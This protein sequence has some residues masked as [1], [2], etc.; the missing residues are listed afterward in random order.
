M[1]KKSTPT[2]F[3]NRQPNID[4]IKSEQYTKDNTPPVRCNSSATPT[5]TFYSTIDSHAIQDILEPL[6]GAEASIHN[7][8]KTFQLTQ[9]MTP[10][11]IP[12]SHHPSFRSTMVTSS[13]HAPLA[14]SQLRTRHTFSNSHA[15]GQLRIP[16]ASLSGE[17]SFP[18][19]IKARKKRWE[20]QNENLFSQ[21]K[22]SDFSL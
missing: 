13:S 20:I 9:P 8:R 5:P 10:T 18:A 22:I 12:P 16:K 15:F 4:A 2:K 7:S 11:P 14:P 3:K 21:L 17:K 1:I 6:P 19:I